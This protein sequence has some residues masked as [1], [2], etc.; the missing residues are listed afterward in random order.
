MSFAQEFGA[1]SPFPGHALKVLHCH[2]LHLQTTLST[3]QG[4][5]FWG[6]LMFVF[7]T[8]LHVDKVGARAQTSKSQK[9][10]AAVTDPQPQ[11]SRSIPFT[12]SPFG[13]EH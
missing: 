1:A 10:Q 2:K 8:G 4:S 3:L 13:Q 6:S 7:Y 12:D 9:P 11:L 5:S